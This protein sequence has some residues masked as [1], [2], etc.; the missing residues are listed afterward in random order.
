MICVNGVNFKK[1]GEGGRRTCFFCP[2]FTW[3]DPIVKGRDSV[4]RGFKIKNCNG[5]ICERPI[6]AIKDLEIHSQ[7]S[8]EIK[9]QQEHK[10]QRPAREAKTHARNRIA[11][12]AMNDF[13]N[14]WQY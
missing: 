14:Q 7:E 5:Y 4:K 10:E 2:T 9:K 6:Q 12:M 11:A 3:N 13:E 8:D 1:I